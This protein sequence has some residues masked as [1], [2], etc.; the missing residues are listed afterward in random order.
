MKSRH[1]LAK[2]GLI[3]CPPHNI[4]IIRLDRMIH[5]LLFVIIRFNR[6]THSLLF[7]IIRL[8]RMIQGRGPQM[9]PLSG[10]P[11]LSRAMTWEEIG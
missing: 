5:S 9:Y 4:V 1:V 7:V 2:S 11:D 6:M 8:D 3:R 10:L